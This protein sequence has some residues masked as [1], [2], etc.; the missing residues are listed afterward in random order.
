MPILNSISFDQLPPAAFSRHPVVTGP[1]AGHP[2]VPGISSCGS[3]FHPKLA[4]ANRIVI[5]QY[6]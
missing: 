2:N 5:S 6:E 3:V 4:F 1:G